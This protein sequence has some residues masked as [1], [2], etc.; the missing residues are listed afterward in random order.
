[1]YGARFGPPA[2]L[3][4]APD[5]DGGR[6]VNP[7]GSR[8][9]GQGQIAASMVGRA[10]GDRSSRTPHGTLRRIQSRPER[11]VAGGDPRPTGRDR[12]NAGGQK[13][14]GHDFGRRPRLMRRVGCPP[15]ALAAGFA[16]AP[17]PATGE[18]K[19]PTPL[20]PISERSSSVSKTGPV[21]AHTVERRAAR[22]AGSRKFASIRLFSFVFGA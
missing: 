5:C 3:A 22:R 15:G 16:P 21:R 13:R 1:M 17:R 18:E 9:K 4:G 7:F 8:V 14:S 20:A 6:I 10:F 19:R 11:L 2:S 12:E